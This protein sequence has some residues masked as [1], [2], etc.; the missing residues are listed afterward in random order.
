MSVEVGHR[1][2]WR[3]RTG[4]RRRT[5]AA[6][7]LAGAAALLLY[8]GISARTSSAEAE[9]EHA[10]VEPVTGTVVSRVTLSAGAMKRIDLQTAATR[11]VQVRGTRRAVIPYGALLYDTNGATWVYARVKPRTFVRHR[12]AVDSIE[13]D[14]A[15]LAAASARPAQVVTVGVPELWGA[16]LGIDES[17]H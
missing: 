8:Q 10:L 15:I 17:G 11:T 13:G 5:I 7:L 9:V 1:E 16:E 14:R 4:R 12:V 2:M 3:D 6:V